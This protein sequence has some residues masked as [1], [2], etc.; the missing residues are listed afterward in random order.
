MITIH[1]A[2]SV[3]STP[4]CSALFSQNRAS[5]YHVLLKERFDYDVRQSSH[6]PGRSATLHSRGQRRTTMTPSHRFK[7]GDFKVLHLG[8]TTL[9]SYAVHS[10]SK[11]KEKQKQHRN[12][13]NNDN[14]GS[15]TTSADSLRVIS[16]RKES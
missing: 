4:A 12:G 16:Q 7:S 10:T 9:T 6:E 2:L 1:S 3:S 13:N 14:I 5:I 11:R 15:V 8:R